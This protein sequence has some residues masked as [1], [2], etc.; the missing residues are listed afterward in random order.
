LGVALDVIERQ[1]V[2][3]FHYTSIGGFLLLPSERGK[4]TLAV[5]LIYLATSSTICNRKEQ[6][7]QPIRNKEKV[8]NR[9]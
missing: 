9:F 1:I 8:K 7:I 2:Q 5:F 4:W 3:L 6:H